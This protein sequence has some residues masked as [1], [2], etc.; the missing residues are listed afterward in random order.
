MTMGRRLLGPAAHAHSAAC[1][2]LCAV[3]LFGG[4]SCS[5]KDEPPG[6]G[7][8]TDGGLSTGPIGSAVGSVGGGA[9]GTGAIGVG[10]GASTPGGGIMVTE[11][12]GSGIEPI[13]IDQ[14]GANNPG[15]LSA[16]QMS[17]L[18]AGGNTGSLRVLYP[19][20][21]TV[22]PRGLTAP[23][24][25]WEGAG[26]AIYVHLKAGKFEYHGCLRANAAGQVELPQDVWNTAGQQTG[27]RNDPLSVELTTLN[28]QTATGPLKQRWVIAQATLK[29]SIYYNSYNTQ[30]SG[31]FGNNGAILRIRPGQMAEVFARQGSCTGCHSVSA[32]GER[33]TTKEF[34][35]GAVEG[36]IGDL[37]GL[38]GGLGGAAGGGIAGAI[39]D[40]Q[41]YALTPDT[42]PN[43][44]PA[45]AAPGTSF[46]GLTPDGKLYLS[47]A[48]TLE[49][50]PQ[51]QGGVG[52]AIGDSLL[53]ETDT[54]T[55]VQNTGIPTTA[56]MPTFSA[57]GSLLTFSDA[58]QAGRAIVVMDFDQ[59]NRKASNARTVLTDTR[60]LGWPF[61]LPDNRAVVFSVTDRRDFSGGGVAISPL[62]ARG[63]F[64]DLG[65]VDLS[66]RKVMLLAKSIGFANEADADAQKTYLPFGAAELHQH[67]YPT[68]SP[69]SAG[70]YFWI[71]FDSVRHYGNKG[72][73]RQL[74]G[75]AIAIASVTELSTGNYE[76]DPSFPAFYLA[77]QELQVANHR[78]FTALDPCRKDGS[79]CETGID[80]CGGFC[81]N[82]ICGRD[83]QR[84]SQTN[85]VCKVK[86]DCCRAQDQCIG[87]FCGV[88][89][90]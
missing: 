55:I 13:A 69:V 26:E 10:A 20:D 11:V 39:A 2:A 7:A 23:T 42:A 70:G 16:A 29:G 72:L 75:A 46:A 71:F 9:A 74:W 19:Y 3:L 28:G 64:S 68:V 47:S 48:A 30:L 58:A 18:K 63:P 33:M 54:G 90:E 88:V 44:P 83:T 35:V 6:F 73:H 43:S 62:A 41:I 76:S 61:V 17:A 40:G 4:G 57:D 80:C 5:G 14:C 56:M 36:I 32:N 60:F 78:A 66:T 77:G 87:G 31:G 85:E 38:L 86:S 89:L 84:C 59:K 8:G 45:R 1:A 65:I 51:L 82:G 25:M 53:Y 52:A 27:G 81:T 67:Y 15:G 49:V 21:G 12:P 37:G 34:G 79:K 22:F 50:G 24:L